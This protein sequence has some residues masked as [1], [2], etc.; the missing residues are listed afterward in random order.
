MPTAL[1]LADLNIAPLQDF[2]AALGDV[3]E[4]APWV[5]EATVAGRPYATVTALHDAMAA[6]VR[7]APPE[8]QLAFI[9]GH[10]ELGSRVKRADLTDASQSEQ[11][12]LGLDRLSSEE[13]TRFSKLN[14]AYR[15]KFHF[16]FII[17][18]RRH[19]RDSILAQFERRLGNDVD[20]ERAAALA[21]IALITRLRLVATG[22]RAGQTQDG[23]TAEHACPRHRRGATCPRRTHHPPRD[24][25]QRAR[26]AGR[27][28]HELR[29]PDRPAADLRRTAADR[30]LRADVPRRRL[31]PPD[32]APRSWTSC[33]SAS[34]LASPRRTTMCRCS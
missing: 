21:E 28:R 33:R 17:C 10:P 32:R 13:F 14:A 6:A 22:G 31:F 8:Q 26:T 25:R 34:A 11:G 18:V 4:H 12:G 1:T 30:D 7:A 19:T 9:A 23:R 16:P 24:R 20:A 15:E 29:R 3:F 27:D 5:A 2:V